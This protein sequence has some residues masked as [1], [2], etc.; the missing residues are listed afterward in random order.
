MTSPIRLTIG[1]RGSPLALA[2]AEIV[3]AALFSILPDLAIEDAVAIRVIKT[4]GDR[5]LDRPLADI[6]GKGLFTKEIEEALYAKEIDLAV[7]SMKDMPTILPDGLA[8]MALLPRADVRDLLIG[9]YEDI[10][11]IPKGA[12]VGTASLRRQAQLLALRPDLQ[13]VPFRGNVQ[14]RLAK[15]ERGDVAATFLAKAGLD[16]LGMHDV[17]AQPLDPAVMLPA[18]AQGAIGIEARVGDRIVGDLL[19][20]LDDPLTSACVTA[21]RAMLAVL[22]GSCRTPIA[23]LAVATGEGS[24]RLEGLVASPDGRS[25]HRHG[26]EGSD[27]IE[28]GRTV[29]DALAIHNHASAGR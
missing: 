16:R 25:V 4:T 5:V 9:P 10:D 26:A 23:G 21:E 18:V 28:L 20:R 1:T 3:R 27:P 11:A 24:Y 29:G 22:D 19:A 14:T 12:V 13:V 6:G 17:P 2:Q 8:I 15:L 7:H